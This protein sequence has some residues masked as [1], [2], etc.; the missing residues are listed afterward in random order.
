MSDFDSPPDLADQ[1]RRLSS[2]I[3]DLELST[4]DLRQKIN[5]A[6]IEWINVG[7][8]GAPAFEAGWNEVASRNSVAFWKDPYGIVHLRGGLVSTT[9]VSGIFTLPVGYRPGVQFL[10]FPA[11]GLGSGNYIVIDNGRVITNGTVSTGT[12]V[13]LEGISFHAAA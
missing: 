10:D 5:A 9:F 8:P 3:R 12:F 7:T 11:A 13:S 6:T 2:R 4:N 1:I